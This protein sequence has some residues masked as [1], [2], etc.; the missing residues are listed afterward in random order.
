MVLPQKRNKIAVT[1]TTKRN[2]IAVTFT[3]KR[4]KIA[5]VLLS[6]RNKIAIRLNGYQTNLSEKQRKKVTQEQSGIVLM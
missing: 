5:M 4:N 3:Q 1:F 2:K 6:K